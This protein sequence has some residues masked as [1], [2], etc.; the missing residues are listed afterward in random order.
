MGELVDIDKVQYLFP[1]TIS[2]MGVHHFLWEHG[3]FFGTGGNPGGNGLTQVIPNSYLVIYW[4][5]K[6]FDIF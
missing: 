6:A 1:L 5:G 4:M 3:K 2:E